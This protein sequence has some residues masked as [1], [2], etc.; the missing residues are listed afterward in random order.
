MNATSSYICTA[1]V[2]LAVD[3][4]QS[5]YRLQKQHI[6]FSEF[7]L[8]QRSVSRTQTAAFV[9]LGSALGGESLDAAEELVE[10]APGLTL[11]VGFADALAFGDLSDEG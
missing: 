8:G 7:L 11:A 1:R 3:R 2:A 6:M 10:E 4:L 9:V 5:Q